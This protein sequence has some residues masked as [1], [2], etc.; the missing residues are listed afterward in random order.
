MVHQATLDTFAPHAVSMRASGARMVVLPT[1]PTFASHAVA[2]RAAL[3]PAD[4]ASMGFARDLFQASWAVP[5]AIYAA[6][7]PRPRRFP[8]SISWTIR[9]GVPKLVHHI[10]WLS[11]WALLAAT[12]MRTGDVFVARFALQMFATGA[13]TVIICPLSGRR[14]QDAIHWVSALVYMCDHV[15]MFGVLGTKPAFVSGFWACFAAMSVCTV[16]ERRALAA[17]APA[18]AQL[19]AAEWGFM[20]GEYGLFIVFLCGMLSGL[21]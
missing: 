19:R 3:T 12:L 17:G 18:Q 4:L 1:L 7:E 14:V 20:L 16:A 10:L 9:K 21:A 13:L 11:G 2:L 5:L 15:V 6:L 8:M